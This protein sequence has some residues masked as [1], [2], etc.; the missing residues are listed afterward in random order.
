M[1]LVW[2]PETASKAYI[3]TVK[4]V[5]IIMEGLSTTSEHAGANFFDFSNE[6]FLKSASHYSS[7][8]IS[9]LFYVLMLNF[10]CDVSCINCLLFDCR[11]NFSNNQASQSLY[12][13]WRLGG[14][15]N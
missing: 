14:T 12:Q 15:P 1:K 8:E 9:N 10:S 3:E 4:S 7:Y 11:V 2:S 13:P 6:N 5:S